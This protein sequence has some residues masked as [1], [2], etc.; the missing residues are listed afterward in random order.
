VVAKAEEGCIAD[1]D[2]SGRSPFLT[3]GIYITSGGTCEFAARFRCSAGHTVRGAGTPLRK[4]DPP[5]PRR[6]HA[7]GPSSLPAGAIFLASEV[8]HPDRR[9]GSVYICTR[10]QHLRQ[11]CELHLAAQALDGI[12]TATATDCGTRLGSARP[13]GTFFHD[14]CPCCHN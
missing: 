10:R 12:N 1:S 11:G 6:P 14:A 7:H 8:Q 3:T 5:P 13:R 2:S 9:S 4:C